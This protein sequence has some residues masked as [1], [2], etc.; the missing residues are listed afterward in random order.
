LNE[1][2]LADENVPSL[3]QA[4]GIFFSPSVIQQVNEAATTY[5]AAEAFRKSIRQSNGSGPSAW[6]ESYV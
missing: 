3:F 5:R 2:R 6:R 4:A 1:L